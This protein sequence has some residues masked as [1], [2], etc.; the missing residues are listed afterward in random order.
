MPL[1]EIN[2]NTEISSKIVTYIVRQTIMAAMI[3][4]KMHDLIEKEVTNVQCNISSDFQFI[5]MAITRR[6]RWN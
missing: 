1:L 2:T 5:K 6:F 3:S 4:Q